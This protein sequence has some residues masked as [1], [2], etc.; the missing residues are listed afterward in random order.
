VIR[1]GRSAIGFNPRHKP[2]GGGRSEHAFGNAIDIN[3]AH[4]PFHSNRTD[5]PA[6]VSET[7]AKHGLTWGGDWK[8][9]SRDPMHFEWTGAKGKPTQTATHGSPL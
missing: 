1:S 8:P 2:G 4:N 7:A 5:L 9:G 6:N 3:P